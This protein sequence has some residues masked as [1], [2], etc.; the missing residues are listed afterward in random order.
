MA[1]KKGDGA[2]RSPRDKRSEEENERREQ[3][4]ALM[5]FFMNSLVDAS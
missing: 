2:R 4:P 5:M 1:G 3:G